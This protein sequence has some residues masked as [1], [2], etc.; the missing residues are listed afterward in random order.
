MPEIHFFDPNGSLDSIGRKFEYIVSSHLIE[1]QPNLIK[2]LASVARLLETGGEYWLIVPDQRYCFDHF[3]PPSRL[4]EVV[5]RHETGQMQPSKWQLMEHRAL[6]THNDCVR[7]WAGDH[8]ESMSNLKSKVESSTR[9]F[10][11]YMGEYFDVHCWQFTPQSF[12]DLVDALN[13][14]EL[15]NFTVQDIFETAKN[16]LEFFCILK[17]GS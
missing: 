12:I 6:T 17:R 1:H 5:M 2:H 10:Y 8:G 7:H 9:E 11:S 14:L 16:D 4:S 15:T 13:L 3:L